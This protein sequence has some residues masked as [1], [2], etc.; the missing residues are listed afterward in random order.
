MIA[1]VSHRGVL[2]I[3]FFCVF[4]MVQSDGEISGNICC[5]GIFCLVMFKK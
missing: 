5:Y 2:R 4:V 1:D 3:R